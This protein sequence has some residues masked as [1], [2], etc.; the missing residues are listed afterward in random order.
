M[1]S[2]AIGSAG[3]QFDVVHQHGIWTGIS[4]VTYKL[5]KK[6]NIPSAIAPHGSLESWALKRSNWKKQI[7]KCFYESRNLNTAACLHATAEPEVSDFRKFG[8]SNPIAVIPNGVNSKWLNSEG[9][10]D[11][12]RKH[13]K[14]DPQKRILL[15]LSRITPKKGLIM[16]LKAI[17][18]I[19]N[20]FENWI[21]LI[22]G[23][24]EFGHKSEVKTLVKDL[25]LVDA[26]KFIR[27]LFNQLK[28]DAFSAA[29]LFI[30]PSY[31]E[32]AP[33]VIL[34]AL[35]AEVP[36]ITTKA[37]PWPELISHECGWW[38]D[39]NVKKI[40]EALKNSLSMSREKLQVMGRN[41]KK[42]VTSKYTWSISAQMTIDLYLWILRQ[43]EIPDF[44]HTNQSS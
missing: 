25:G 2:F 13:F 5:V 28:R 38:V 1:E 14:I 17:S 31:S 44:V 23:P 40:C 12:F 29:D 24:D 8:L 22:I 3:G 21:L 43:R 15:F 37:S 9:R 6:H 18:M 36:V 42:L 4:R 30:L 10:S 7:A 26:V 27:P 11:N 41:G 32:G 19:M 35:A 16:L 20:D 39:I 33:I 34:E